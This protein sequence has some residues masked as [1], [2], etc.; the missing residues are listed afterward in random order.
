MHRHTA[1]KSKSFTP[2]PCYQS[3]RPPGRNTP[4]PL[5]PPL[6]ESFKR[7][8][9]VDD[10]SPCATPWRSAA[11]SGSTRHAG[12]H[13]AFGPDSNEVPSSWINRG[14]WRGQFGNDDGT[15]NT[16]CRPYRR[17]AD[18]GDAAHPT[19]R[20]AIHNLPHCIVTIR[21]EGLPSTQVGAWCRS[22]LTPTPTD[23]RY[24]RR[25]CR[26]QPHRVAATRPRTP[27]GFNVAAGLF[28]M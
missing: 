6:G 14:W 10:C 27:G 15:A 13:P 8:C 19:C 16:T 26:L 18:G 20:V 21:A 28:R 12:S 3:R 23:H 7:A 5:L 9:L 22:V 17:R 24:D 2:L 11:R 4:T 1:G 25:R